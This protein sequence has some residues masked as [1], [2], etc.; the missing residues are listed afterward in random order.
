MVSRN[1]HKRVYRVV[2]HD[3][4]ENMCKVDHDI[5]VGHLR[6]LFPSS[7]YFFVASPF[8]GCSLRDVSRIKF[9]IAVCV[10]V[11]VRACCCCD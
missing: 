11:Q 6:A 7:G 9:A 10:G 2:V 4:R 5:F 1:A 8:S 3:W